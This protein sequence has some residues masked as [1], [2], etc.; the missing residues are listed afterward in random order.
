MYYPLFIRLYTTNQIVSLNV[1]SITRLIL[2]LV[3]NKNEP[4]GSIFYANTKT[5]PM[6]CK[7]MIP[8][9]CILQVPSCFHALFRSNLS[10]KPDTNRL[11]E[12]V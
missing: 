10:N 3:N 9:V 11:S 1:T 6:H 5:W 4:C 12:K 7:C 2:S 8:I